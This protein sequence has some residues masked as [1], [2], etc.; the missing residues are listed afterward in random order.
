MMCWYSSTRICSAVLLSSSVARTLG[1]QLRAI[2]VDCALIFSIC[3]NEKNP[4]PIVSATTMAKP[5]AMRIQ[6]F[7]LPITYLPDLVN[8]QRAPLGARTLFATF[9]RRIDSVL[10][11]R[12]HI[13]NQCDFAVTEDARAAHAARV[14]K[15][16][17]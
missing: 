14:L 8:R 2:S 12:R 3:V 1:N 5:I 17:R 16:L 6:I 11:E 10:N 9:S 15:H 7:K 4:R 13:E